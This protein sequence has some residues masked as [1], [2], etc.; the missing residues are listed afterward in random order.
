MKLKLM[1]LSVS[2]VLRHNIV[3][4][5]KMPHTFLCKFGEQFEDCLYWTGMHAAM[6]NGLHRRHSDRNK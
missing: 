3:L 1:L 6:G 5:T 4:N 2:M